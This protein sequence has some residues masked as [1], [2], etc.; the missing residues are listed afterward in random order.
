[1]SAPHTAAT[2]DLTSVRMDAERDA[3]LVHRWLTHPKSKYW[4][5]LDSTVHDVRVMIRDNAA[6]AGDSVHGMRMGYHRGVPQFLFELYDPTTSELAEPT[7]GYVPAAGDIGMHLLVAHAEDPLPGFTG[8]VM[9]H[10][11]SAALIEAGASRVVVEPDI[12][13]E[14]VQRLNAAVGFEVAG[15]H[16]VGDKMARLSYC[17]HADFLRATDGGRHLAADYHRPRGEQQ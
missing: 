3:E 13:N 17:T 16:P 15:D 7:S 4:D 11:M 5:M 6:A 10:I 1:M 14:S 2:T 12:R 9:L 8:A